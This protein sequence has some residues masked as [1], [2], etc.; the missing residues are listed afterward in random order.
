M[1][2]SF[3]ALQKAAELKA[4]SIIETKIKD[5]YHF[6]NLDH[7][8]QVVSACEEM[9]DYYQLNDDD[10]LALAVAAWF[11]DTGYSLGETN[12]ENAGIAIAKEF[13][14]QQHTDAQLIDKVSSCI[15]ATQMPQQ[16]ANLLEEIICDADLFHLGTEMVGEAGKALRREINLTK[17]VQISKTEWAKTNIYF[18]EKHQYFTVYCREKLEPVKQEYIRKLRKK[19]KLGNE[20][21]N[22]PE[23]IATYKGHY[24]PQPTDAD[25]K[26][27]EVAGTIP[28]SQIKRDKQKEK[29]ARMVRGVETMFRIT[30]SNNFRLSSMAD[31]KAHIM[32]SVNSIIISIVGS[33]LLE[34]LKGFPH[35]IVP[36]I[37]LTITCLVAII[38]SVLATRPN[39]SKGKF[40]REDIAAKKTN[41]LFFG[42]F[43]QMDLE[44]YEW[45]MK[46]MMK[47]SDYLYGSM[48]RDIYFLGVV[49]ARKYKLLR[50]AYNVFMYGLV[51]STIAFII[52][53]FFAPAE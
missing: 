8:R 35:Y 2:P 42:N 28:D 33:R 10:R 39:V 23:K 20:I 13:L 46:E 53:S 22:L 1:N 21:I 40:S 31:S 27:T 3:T 4:C 34:K 19:Y 7:T 29:V 16:P 6:H 9:A 43:F 49:L 15:A 41:L 50:I 26:T 51:L 5:I 25:K 47:D 38:F 52:A 18:M 30:S 48:V 17:D 11:H 45:A 32:I 36:T 44:E 14:E 24:T 12:H 37:I